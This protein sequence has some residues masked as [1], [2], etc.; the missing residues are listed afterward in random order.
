MHWER[1]AFRDFTPTELYEILR[2]RNE[3]FVVEQD[4]VYQ[5]CDGADPECEHLVGRD[6]QGRLAAYLR[7]VPAGL[8]YSE[9]S[10]GRVLTAPFARGTGAGKALIAEAIRL[11]GKD[12]LR[13]S[14]QKYLEN[15]YA[16]YGFRSVGEAYLEDGIPH[17]KMVKA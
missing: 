1:K 17:I 16:G 7:F 6:S 2:L 8:K 9:A 11:H 5:D 15:F 4:C 10:I 14:A 12:A 13:I 3:V